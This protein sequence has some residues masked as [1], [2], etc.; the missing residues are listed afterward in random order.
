L[1][2]GINC[3]PLSVASKWV[4]SLSLSLSLSQIYGVDR[5]WYVGSALFNRVKLALLASSLNSLSR[6]LSPLVFR[7]LGWAW[8]CIHVDVEHDSVLPLTCRLQDALNDKQNELTLSFMV[9]RCCFDPV[10]VVEDPLYDDALCILK[11][12]CYLKF[13]QQNEIR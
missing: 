9:V 4:Y 1:Y 6:S 10:V 11:Q 7:A 5:C 12:W 2:P 13:M 3:T 8:S